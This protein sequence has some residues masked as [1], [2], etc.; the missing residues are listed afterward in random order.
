M[1]DIELFPE[2]ERGIR[3]LA[4]AWSTPPESVALA[5]ITRGLKEHLTEDDVNKAL[6]SDKKWVDNYLSKL[7]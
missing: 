2:Q 5:L 3:I 1:M 4:K 7:D 6:L